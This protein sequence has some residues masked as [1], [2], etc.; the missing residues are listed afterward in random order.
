ME[1]CHGNQQRGN[2]W[3]PVAVTNVPLTTW[4]KWDVKPQKT[5]HSS[6]SHNLGTTSHHLEV[7]TMATDEDPAIT[8]EEKDLTLTVIAE[9]EDKTTLE[10]IR[11]VNGHS[12][13]NLP[14]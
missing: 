11:D 8:A 10:D 2:W 9:L 3:T 12:K 14:L 13:K 5:P 7:A 1:P 6:R 4:R